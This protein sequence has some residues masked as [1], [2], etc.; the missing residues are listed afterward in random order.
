MCWLLAVPAYHKDVDA[1][2]QTHLATENI[3]FFAAACVR[4]LDMDRAD[5]IAPSDLVGDKRDMLRVILC[6]QDV[7][8]RMNARRR[9]PPF[10]PLPPDN[11]GTPH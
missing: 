4:E 6:V 10:T 1:A 9:A 7:A 2:K 5:V 3:A 8:R 11:E